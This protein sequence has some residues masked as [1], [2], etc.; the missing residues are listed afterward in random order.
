MLPIFKL[1]NLPFWVQPYST[2]LWSSTH[3]VMY[4]GFN[5]AAVKLTRDMLLADSC[6][7]F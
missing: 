6:I 2:N 3:M 7:S 1:G 5:P 4:A